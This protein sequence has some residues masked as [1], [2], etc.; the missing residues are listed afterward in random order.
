MP[1]TK[2]L[3]GIDI[4]GTSVKTALVTEQ[5]RMVARG[6]V[7]TPDLAD[8]RACREFCQSLENFARTQGA[9]A[10]E[11]FGVGVAIP[12]TVHGAGTGLLPNVSLDVQLLLE[13][14]HDRFAL[15]TLACLNDAN[16]AALAEAR[17]GSGRGVGT[18]VFV[19]VGTGIGAGI[20]IDGK[21]LEGAA[22]AAGE[23]GHLRVAKGGRRCNCGK[24]GCLEQYASARGI[25]RS[26]RETDAN[27]PALYADLGR[28]ETRQPATS[29]PLHESD[30]KSVFEAYRA[31]DVRAVSAVSTFTK[32]LGFALGQVATIVNPDLF[33]LGGGVSQSAA[34]F[35]PALVESFRANCIA[36][37]EKTPLKVAELGNAAGSLGA[38]LYA[39]ES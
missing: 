22:G 36:P 11:I 7:P 23:I 38:A 16:A 39:M 20:V 30:S 6:Q 31:G 15:A 10:S 18:V 3:I 21:L 8:A 9:P 2:Q 5:G 17:L 19:T 29:Y 25:V 32:T 33:V 34:L 26:F 14:L 1:R 27:A 12:G 35:F 24:R 13:Q 4:G 37:C 28:A